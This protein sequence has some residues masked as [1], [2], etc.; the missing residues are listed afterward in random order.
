M[1]EVRPEI[2]AGLAPLLY[3]AA[4]PAARPEELIDH[5][6][7]AA[8]LKASSGEPFALEAPEHRPAVLFF[9]VKNG[10]PG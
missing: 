2:V 7:P 1:L 10:S 9:Y 5:P 3:G 4:M 6:L 8:T